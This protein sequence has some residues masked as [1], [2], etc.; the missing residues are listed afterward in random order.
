[1][2]SKRHVMDC[3]K[4]VFVA[5]FI[6][7]A[8]EAARALVLHPWP[9]LG[10][11]SFGKWEGVYFDYPQEDGWRPAF[12]TLL[13]FKVLVPSLASLLLLRSLPAM[14]ASRAHMRDYVAVLL[15]EAVSMILF[16]FLGQDETYGNL[17]KAAA[18][19]IP[20]VL[21]IL[22]I[23]GLP[24]PEKGG[25]HDLSGGLL[26]AAMLVAWLFVVVAKPGAL[27]AVFLFNLLAIG[28]AEEFAFRGVIQGYLMR[29]CPGHGWLGLSR[30]NVLTASLFAW[31]HNPS[32]DPQQLSWLLFTFAMGLAMGVV[33]ERT[34]S[35]FAPAL[36]HGANAFY[37]LYVMLHT[38]I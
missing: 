18:L 27:V 29:R 20:W 9:L 7:G 6:F 1:M 19:A 21:F 4:A 13:L 2:Y 15:F 3:I 24:V 11:V 33:R 8:M 23:K 22:L 10:D 12:L 26:I 28:F 35:W 17:G 5:L 16:H 36:A 32:L 37:W 30:A 14:V 38:R 31:S 25:G 34:G